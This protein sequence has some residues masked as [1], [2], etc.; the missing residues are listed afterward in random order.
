MS[1]FPDR[2][3]PAMDNLAE[4]LDTLE[5]TAF[6]ARKEKRS[7]FPS[8]KV[9]SISGNQWHVKKYNFLDYIFVSI[10]N[11]FGLLSSTKLENLQAKFRRDSKGIKDKG[12][13]FQ[14]LRTFL[15][16]PEKEPKEEEFRI[17][18]PDDASKI[19]A[20]PAKPSTD[21]NGKDSVLE[22]ASQL[23]DSTEDK[24]QDLADSKASRDDAW[25]RIMDK[26]DLPNYDIPIIH[27][28]DAKEDSD[29][30][31]TG[32]E[33]KA[34]LPASKPASPKKE[35]LLPPPAVPKGAVDL[36]QMDAYEGEFDSWELEREI[37]FLKR[38]GVKGDLK[39]KAAEKIRERNTQTGAYDKT[40]IVRKPKPAEMK[41]AIPEAI[42]APSPVS[43]AENLLPSPPVPRAA[44]SKEG[45]A[46]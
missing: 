34:P 43:Q 42:S 22:V 20:Q 32:S 11:F 24:S 44:A 30:T 2:M 3:D 6:K 19:E 39:R 37:N 15:K 46:P 29:K 26:I 13:N 36:S 10:A 17:V 8:C 31:N 14:F 25:A 45:S 35:D 16:L 12:P 23:L 28:A 40:P 4:F 27:F 33:E 1:S 7:L 21:S 5:F 38:I 18:Y 41:A 9:L